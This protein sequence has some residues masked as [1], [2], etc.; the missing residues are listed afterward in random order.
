MNQYWHRSIC[1]DNYIE[2]I[3][4]YRKELRLLV[5][6]MHFKLFRDFFHKK[7]ILRQNIRRQ[8]RSCALQVSLKN[9]KKMS[10]H[11]W[12]YCLLTKTYSIKLEAQTIPL[13]LVKNVS[14]SIGNFF[15]FNKGNLLKLLQDT[16]LSFSPFLFDIKIPGTYDQ[17][18]F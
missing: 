12:H 1:F 6:R 16:T 15:T 18:L 7:I 13:L 14:R 9:W 8:C 17:V 11:N 5:L 4:I 3:L 2:S 10:T